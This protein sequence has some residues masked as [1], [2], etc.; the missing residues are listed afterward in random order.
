MLGAWP[1][2]V[3]VGRQDGDDLKFKCGK[4]FFLTHRFCSKTVKI[5]QFL[6]SNRRFIDNKSPRSYCWPLH[7]KRVRKMLTTNL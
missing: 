6:S 7:K 1:W 2:I 5:N 3:A 4:L